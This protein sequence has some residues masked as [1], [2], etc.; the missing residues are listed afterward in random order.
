MMTIAAIHCM[1]EV[2]LPF[3]DESA[4]FKKRLHVSNTPTGLYFVFQ[5][6]SLT[7][8]LHLTSSDTC[9]QHNLF[10]PFDVVVTEFNHTLRSLT[11]SSLLYTY[12]QT[13]T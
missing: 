4:E 6:F 8:T 12:L 7:S 3:L 1:H 10:S 5:Y 11:I 2:A 13:K 9:L